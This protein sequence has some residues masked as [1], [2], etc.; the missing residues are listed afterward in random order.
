MKLSK[1][2]RATVVENFIN[3]VFGKRIEEFEK[4]AEM[5]VLAHAANQF[6]HLLEWSE[7]LTDEQRALVRHHHSF[8]ICS[9]KENGYNEYF[10]PTIEATV[11][12]DP[13]AYKKEKLCWLGGLRSRSYSSDFTRIKSNVGY[14]SKSDMIVVDGELNIKHL[15][16][17]KAQLEREIV[18]TGGKLYSAL[19]TVPS[20]AKAVEMMPDLEQYFPKPEKVSQPLVPSELYSNINAL[21]KG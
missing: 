9:I 20:K 15:R 2:I 14:P 10:E 16:E 6:G 5:S 19:L 1:K 21:I 13:T 17:T 8:A 12:V 11:Y 4:E 7:T 3:G 18:D